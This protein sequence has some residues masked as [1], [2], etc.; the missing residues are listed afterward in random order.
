MNFEY[1]NYNVWER[2]KKSK[3]AIFSQITFLK[4]RKRGELELERF[5]ALPLKCNTK[6]WSKCIDL[7]ENSFP[8]D[9]FAKSLTG[10]I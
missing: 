3:F 10:K 4:K 6:I 9:T 2:H 5:Y 8:E 1:I 7:V